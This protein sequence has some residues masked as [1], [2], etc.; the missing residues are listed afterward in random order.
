MG[1]STVED[2]FTCE[3]CGEGAGSSVVCAACGAL[4]EPDERDPFRA[5]GLERAFEL[6][7]KALRRSLMKMQRA[8]HPDFFAVQGDAAREAAERA[9]S[10][11]NAAFEVLED[12]LRRADWLVVA[13]GGPTRD[14]DREMP[15]AFLM[16]VLEWNEV[17]EEARDAA[18]RDEAALAEL[19]SNLRT[20]RAETVDD[21]AVGLTPLPPT[22]DARLAQVRRHLNALRYVDRAL[23]EIDA[24]R[25]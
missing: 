22:G 25:N 21:V 9:T 3:R 8:T 2:G 23:G 20:A 6:D 13:Q 4:L 1:E 10:T 19:E 11:L 7:A 18:A 12:P 17:L 15:Q 16:E 14:Q 24:L 5:F